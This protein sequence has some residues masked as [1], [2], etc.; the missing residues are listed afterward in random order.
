MV[1]A[2]SAGISTNP[3]LVGETVSYGRIIIQQYR[4]WQSHRS[5]G[6]FL[7]VT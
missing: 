3:I 7:I 5:N 2:N 6:D 1:L 4:S